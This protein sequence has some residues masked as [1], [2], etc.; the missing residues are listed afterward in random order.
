MSDPTKVIL[1]AEDDPD[2]IYLI[3]EAIDECQLRATLILAQDGEEL[4]DILNRRGKYQDASAYPRPDLILLDLNMPRMDG[5]EA[6]AALKRDPDLA[7]IPVI[8]LTTSKSNQDLDQSYHL[9]ASG[10]VTKPVTFGE[11]RDAIR[12]IGSYWIN[13][14]QLPGDLPHSEGGK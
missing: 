4:L 8:V 7:K 13:T 12:H 2:D 5:R 6:L 3:S 1:L 14:V 10:F 11:L 9:G